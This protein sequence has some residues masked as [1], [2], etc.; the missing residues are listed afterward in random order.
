MKLSETINAEWKEILK[1]PKELGKWIKEVYNETDEEFI[2]L[3]VKI[4]KAERMT[5]KEKENIL[6]EKK[7]KIDEE[8]KALRDSKPKKTRTKKTEKK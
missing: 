8:L 4:D 2:K 7:R 3:L 1:T 5:F 6:K